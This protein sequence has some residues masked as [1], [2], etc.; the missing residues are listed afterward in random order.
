MKKS[1]ITAAC[2]L[3]FGFFASAQED[4]KIEENENAI[5]KTQQEPPRETQRRVERSTTRTAE[6]QAAENKMS[7]AEKKSKAK[8]SEAQQKAK[9]EI[10]KKNE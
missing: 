4:Q 7:E 10:D 2:L 6:Q 5:D 3:A 9:P 1:L 8:N